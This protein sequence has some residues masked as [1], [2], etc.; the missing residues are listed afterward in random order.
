MST[1]EPKTPGQ[2]K[3]STGIGNDDFDAGKKVSKYGYPVIGLW[4]LKTPI[5]IQMLKADYK[6]TIPQSFCF[7]PKAVADAEKVEDMEKVL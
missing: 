1:T 4:K 6:M 7:L 2:V 5:T 3:D